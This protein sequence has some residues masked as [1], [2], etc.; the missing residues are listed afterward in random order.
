MI[1]FVRPPI[2]QLRPPVAH[3]APPGD[4]ATLYPVIA[5]PPSDDG[6]DQLSVTWPFPRVAVNPV[7]APGVVAGVAEAGAEGGPVPTAFVAA[8]VNE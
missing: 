4:A 7:G 6:A 8:T 2:V 5:D 1:P 3:V